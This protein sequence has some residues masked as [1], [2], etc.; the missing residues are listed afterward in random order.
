[1]ATERCPQCGGSGTMG[2]TS[3]YC[4]N[5]DCQNYVSEDAEDHVGE[6]KRLLMLDAIMAH[7]PLTVDSAVT[8]VMGRKTN[9][10]YAIR[11]FEG[12]EPPQPG[13]RSRLLVSMIFQGPEY[14]K[15]DTYH[16]SVGEIP[17]ILHYLKYY[18]QYMKDG[19]RGLA[20]MALKEA[21][22]KALSEA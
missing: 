12:S 4:S 3:F 6:G 15:V 13:D 2:F 14:K 5:P 10:V 16:G 11:A 21:F 22:R 9:I 19:N 7:H 1:M 17:D 20:Q 18:N 8:Y